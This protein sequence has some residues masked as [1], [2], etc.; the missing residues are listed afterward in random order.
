ME[1][2]LRTPLHEAHIRLGGRMVPF[3]GF[4]MPVQYKSI[5]AESKAVREG[6]GMFDV[7]HMA[8]LQFRGA[9][10]TEFMEWI[11]TNDVSKLA[12]NEGHYSLLPNERGG[13]VD[14]IILYRLAAD[15]YTMVVNADFDSVADYLA[16][17]DN[18]DH[19]RVI[20][21]LGV[22]IMAQRAAVQFEW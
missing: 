21:E 20:K 17:R 18:P 6:A 9:R 14:D 7:S 3:A 22:P 2:L 16:Y 10:S 4:E 13:C 15:R 19:Q 11:T 5:I 12:D 8:R 1:T